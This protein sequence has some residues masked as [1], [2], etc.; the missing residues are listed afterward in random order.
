MGVHVVF[1]ARHE[2]SATDAWEEADERRLSSGG[3]AAAIAVL[4]AAVLLAAAPAVV[5][6]V[7]MVSPGDLD[8]TFG[9]LA[10]GSI[11]FSLVAAGRV[12]AAALFVFALALAS[13]RARQ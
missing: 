10:G 8:R 4:C 2:S 9:W 13:R 7:A 3:S 6:A 12:P 11:A 5:A 1:I